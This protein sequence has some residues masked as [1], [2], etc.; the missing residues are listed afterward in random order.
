MNSKSMNEILK[1]KEENSKKYLK[2]TDKERKEDEKRVM[3]W[4]LSVSKKSKSKKIY[5]YD[6]FTETTMHIAEDTEK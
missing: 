4:F 6:N 1:I 5:N 2:M 3:E